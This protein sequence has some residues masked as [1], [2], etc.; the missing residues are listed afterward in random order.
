M[1]IDTIP[2]SIP[3]GKVRAILREIGV[4]PKWCQSLELRPDGIYATMFVKGENG[5]K[6]IDGDE[7]ATHKVFIKIK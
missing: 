1:L 7:V 5:G 6:V 2:E 4:D 3:R